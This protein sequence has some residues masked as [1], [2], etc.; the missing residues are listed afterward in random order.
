MGKNNT[1]GLK[2]WKYSDTRSVDPLVVQKLP[3]KCLKGPSS[4]LISWCIH[5][6]LLPLV[7]SPSI[8]MQ[9]SPR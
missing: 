9:A 5:L 8:K 6:D 4:S 3:T 1:V 7:I 2:F